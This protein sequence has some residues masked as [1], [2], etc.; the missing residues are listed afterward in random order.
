VL[1][2]G[3]R[4]PVKGELIGAGVQKP[5]LEK[6]WARVRMRCQR[7]PRKFCAHSACCAPTHIPTA[8]SKILSFA[9][10]SASVEGEVA[11]PTIPAR[12]LSSEELTNLF[13]S[14]R[15]S[16]WLSWIQHQVFVRD[17]PF[18]QPSTS[19]YLEP[20]VFFQREMTRRAHELSECGEQVPSRSCTV[21]SL[22][23]DDTH[24]AVVADDAHVADEA[25]AVGSELLSVQALE[26]GIP[27]LASLEAS[28]NRIDAAYYVAWVQQH[29]F[30]ADNPDASDDEVA[31][32][33]FTA[34]MILRG[35][36]L[37]AVESRL[38][39]L[40]WRRPAARLVNDLFPMLAVDL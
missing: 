38:M 21:V 20:M 8:A 39:G 3:A 24:D 35:R 22:F 28:W 2:S 23:L 18:E 34:Q 13:T 29:L 33:P 32:T 5:H 4:A 12:I 26:A 27:L 16:Y 7:G 15:R 9:M 36:A 25:A 40:G 31:N 11:I 37:D 17:N 1:R 19:Q 6:E 10:A 14:A 30:I